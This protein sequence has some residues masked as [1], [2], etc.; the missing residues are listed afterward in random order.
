MVF[1]AETLAGVGSG[2][3]L[4]GLQLGLLREQKQI[5]HVEPKYIFKYTK[6]HQ[7]IMN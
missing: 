6:N 1:K 3:A 2:E 7:N 5:N 4:W